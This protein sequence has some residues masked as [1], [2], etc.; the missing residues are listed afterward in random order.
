[1]SDD[2]FTETVLVDVGC[3]NEVSS[4][5]DELVKDLVGDSFIALPRTTSLGRRGGEEGGRD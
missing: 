2:S 5:A 4:S 3:V 1:M